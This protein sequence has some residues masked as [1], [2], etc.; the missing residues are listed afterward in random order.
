MLAV[1]FSKPKMQQGDIISAT[2]GAVLR[3]L[4]GPETHCASRR[5]GL[6]AVQ[7]MGA[8]SSRGTHRHTQSKVPHFDYFFLSFAS[9]RSDGSPA[10]SHQIS[11]GPSF[12]FVVFVLMS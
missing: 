4:S 3:M 8:V 9:G 1:T 10:D 7:M 2:S 11:I 5:D 12:P 6:A